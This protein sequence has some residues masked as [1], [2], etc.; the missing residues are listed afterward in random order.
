MYLHRKDSVLKII[1]YIP[2]P[3]YQI[4]PSSSLSEFEKYHEYTKNIE[5]CYKKNL[6]LNAFNKLRLFTSHEI[7]KY[8]KNNG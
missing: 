4:K 7:N 8:M 6:L 1:D 5:P 3:L 2:N